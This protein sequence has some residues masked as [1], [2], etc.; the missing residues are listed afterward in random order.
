MPQDNRTSALIQFLIFWQGALTLAALAGIAAL[1][2]GAFTT[3]LAAQ[4]GGSILLL[5]AAI[6]SGYAIPLLRARNHRG[7]LIAF[8]VNYLGFLVSFLYALHIMGVF[9]GIDTLADTFGKGVLWLGGVMLGYLISAF[10]DRYDNYPQRQKFFRRAGGAL[11]VLFGALFLIAVGIF[12]ALGY[13]LG[14]LTQL[15]PLLFTVFAALFAF[16]L[17]IL[18]R[19]QT[20]HAFHAKVS[21]EEMISGYLFLSPNLLGFL[22]FFAG[23]LLLSLYF[24]FTNWDAF[25]THDWIGLQNYAKILDLTIARLQTPNQIFTEVIDAARYSELFRFNVFGNWFLV[26]AQDKLFWLALRNT[27]VFGLLTVPLSVVPALLLANLLNS[28]LPGMKFFRAVYFLP[29]IAAVVGIALVWQWLYNA[30]VGYINYFITVGVNFVNSFGFM[31]ID[32]QIRWLSDSRT[33]LLAVVIM[34]AWQ[35]MGFNTVLFLAGL[36][37]I[38]GELYEAATVDGAGAWGKFWNVTLPLLAPTTFFVLTTSIIQALQVFEQVYVLIPTEP[39]GGPNNAT[40]TLVL[41]L[42]QKGFQRFEQGYASAVAWVLFLIIFV[43]TLF[44]FRNQRSSAYE[45]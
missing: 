22:F 45:N 16:S 15:L 14:Q 39:P 24:S 26:G 35:W 34:A 27:F 42:Y 40:L 19:P 10:G 21:H 43:F 44:Q 32:P 37:N 12:P 38:P 5:G 33:A 1:W 2:G 20:A 18:N 8:A 17:W 6:A 25:G 11:M 28:K 4:L 41:Y 36:Q 30:A 29:S 7:R 23:P 13:L 3:G 9:L 31:L